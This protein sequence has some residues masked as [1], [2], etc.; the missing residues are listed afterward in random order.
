VERPLHAHPVG[1]SGCQENKTSTAAEVERV[2][3]EI[4]GENKRA[5]DNMWGSLVAL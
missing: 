1:V 5:R 2:A 3:L 4:V